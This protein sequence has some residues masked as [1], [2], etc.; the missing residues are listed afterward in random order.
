MRIPHGEREMIMQYWQ[1]LLPYAV[2]AV[3]LSAA[4]R[5]AVRKYKANKNRDFTRKLETLL[6]PRETVKVICPQKG[7]S[8]ILTSK[9]ILFEKGGNFSAYPLRDIQRL[10][11]TNAAGNRTT[12]PKNM[13]SLTIRLEEDRTLKNTGAEFE[14]LAS[15]LA[16]KVKKN[17]ERAAGKT[18]G[19]K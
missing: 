15:Q 8:C 3:L 11:G 6:Q 1:K 9:R 13:V 14:E 16:E 12:V 4:V 5:R 10:Q 2:L 18:G 17:K 19:G 7:G